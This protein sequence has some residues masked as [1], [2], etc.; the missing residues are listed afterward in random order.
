M[1]RQSVHLFV[2]I[3]LALLGP[4]A[5]KCRGD[6]IL[7][8][9]EHLTVGTTHIYGYLYDVSRAFIVPGGWV[10]TLYG[11]NFSAVDISGGSVGDL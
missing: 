6:F 8:N 3:I 4:L 2:A 7:Y 10:T 1:K 5:Q 9:N 11:Y